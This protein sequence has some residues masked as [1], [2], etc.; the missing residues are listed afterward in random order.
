MKKI[1][2]TLVCLCMLLGLSVCVPMISDASF[3]PATV[4]TSD[5]ASRKDFSN[6]F[7][8]DDPINS[9]NKVLCLP[10]SGLGNPAN[11][12]TNLIDK[13]VDGYN[14]YGTDSTSI[15]LSSNNKGFSTVTFDIYADSFNTTSNQI[16]R[17]VFGSEARFSKVNVKDV[18]GVSHDVYTR[19]VGARWINIAGLTKSTD[20]GN[21]A[22]LMDS[23][24]GWSGMK[25]EKKK[26]YTVKNVIDLKNL[27]QSMYI[28]ENGGEFKAVEF[29]SYSQSDRKWRYTDAYHTKITNV[30]FNDV[31][32]CSF[33]T[34]IINGT[35]YYADTTCTYD[36]D[37]YSR[38]FGT[39]QFMW[40]AQ[41]HDASDTTYAPST[42]TPVTG[43]VN[44]YIANVKI[45]SDK[46][47]EEA[48]NS[49]TTVNQVKDYLDYYASNGS[50]TLTDNEEITDFELVYKG[51]MNK[52]FASAS[53]VQSEYNRLCE[54][55]ASGRYVT[56]DFVNTSADGGRMFNVKAGE[57][58][59]TTAKVVNNTENVINV[60][61][62]SA[63]YSDSGSILAVELTPQSVPG[64]FNTADIS[65][66]ITVPDKS[67]ISHI[68]Q[69]VINSDKNV[70]PYCTPNKVPCVA[71]DY[72]PTL[73]I[74]GDSLCQ[75]YDTTFP[76]SSTYGTVYPY[77]GW[78]YYMSEFLDGINVDNRARSGWTTEHFVHP[79][80]KGVSGSQVYY[81]W[82]SF[83]DLINPGDYVLVGLGIND[84]GS[85]N[86]SEDRY[87]ENL[88]VMYNDTVNA[89]ATPLYSTPT[90]WGGSDGSSDG[91]TYSISGGWGRRGE[92]CR[93]FAES[94]GV[95]CVPFGKTLSETYEN[96]YQNYMAEHTDATVAEGRDY[97][98]HYFH[99]YQSDL[100]SGKFGYAFTDEQISHH[101][102]NVR[103][104]D[105]ATH[106]NLHGAEKL[107]EIMCSLIKDS[108]CS[109]KDYVK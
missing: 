80:N 72:T 32:K 31:N 2:S 10:Y 19:S 9:E 60:Y 18:T 108:N 92:V 49:A 44:H 5:F 99:I 71:S 33:N 57:S 41:S 22:Y 7:V 78:G 85:G 67:G 51:L 42:F 30:G 103:K 14:Y 76:T 82:D 56:V 37:N 70:K 63:L 73:Y 93:N 47:L 8:T 28:S 52:N 68:K 102:G 27:T 48:I 55:V 106:V 50:I 4:Y 81:T 58:F 107:A 34:V 24:S 96:M 65:Q 75:T 95:A 23:Q 16:W 62:I 20:G 35:T 77:Q 98:R 87:I 13:K 86:I 109:L 1:V 11:N 79:E 83:K 15:G 101:Y 69:F 36:A 17:G 91:W 74:V 40:I 66:T 104:G 90:I 84:S 94:K 54:A 100:K 12:K 53:S 21:T 88:E 45:T 97:V 6:G 29:P 64:G 43:S 61:L 25:L 39:F 38:N 105:D 3:E 89:G 59:N 26:W 46:P